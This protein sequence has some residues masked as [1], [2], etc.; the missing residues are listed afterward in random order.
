MKIAYINQIVKVFFSP[1]FQ[2]IHPNSTAIFAINLTKI[3]L[4][5]IYLI[6]NLAHYKGKKYAN[7]ASI[8][9]GR[10]KCYPSAGY[11]SRIIPGPTG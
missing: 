6:S 10:P 3:Y 4:H 5:D 11:F 8:A 9:T 2:E 7:S 1:F